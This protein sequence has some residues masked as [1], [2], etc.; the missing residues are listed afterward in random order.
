[1]AERADGLILF[2]FSEVWL[3]L[4]P[5]HCEESM[6]DQARPASHAGGAGRQSDESSLA[7]LHPKQAEI[8]FGFKSKVF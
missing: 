7:I 2:Y 8:R 1:M 5:G 4:L 6:P 3:S